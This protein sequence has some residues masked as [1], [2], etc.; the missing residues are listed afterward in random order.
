[1]A[2]PPRSQLRP[3]LAAASRCFPRRVEVELGAFRKI[4]NI[5]DHPFRGRQIC[6]RGW[7]W[8]LSLDKRQWNR[9]GVIDRLSGGLLLLPFACGLPGSCRS[10][11]V[12]LE[13]SLYGIVRCLSER[14]AEVRRELAAFIH[15][16]SF[17][18]AFRIAKHRAIEA[19]VLRGLIWLITEVAR[20]SRRGG[21]ARLRVEYAYLRIRKL[22][23]SRLPNEPRQAN[24]Q[25]QGR[26]RHERHFDEAPAAG[27][28]DV[29]QRHPFVEHI[30]R[31]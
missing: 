28:P 17:M 7:L 21:H 9:I 19:R 22:H 20:M 8:R 27:P 3:S 12:R 5:V 15:R 25:E 26:C 31:P 29:G 14:N 23:A 2:P 1:M 13:V 30:P 24:Q 11:G 10:A 18:H 16:L 6:E 4:L